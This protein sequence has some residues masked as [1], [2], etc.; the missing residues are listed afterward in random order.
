[1]GNMPSNYVRNIACKAN[2]CRYI[3]VLFQEIHSLPGHINNNIVN[4]IGKYYFKNIIMCHYLRETKKCNPPQWYEQL[5]EIQQLKIQTR[6][7]TFCAHFLS[8]SVLSCSFIFKL[9][10]LL[11]SLL[12]LFLPSFRFLGMLFQNLIYFVFFLLSAFFCLGGVAVVWAV[13][14]NTAG[15]S[16]VLKVRER[17]R[18][19]CW[20]G[21]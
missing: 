3:N 17:R 9:I 10:W 11:L 6:L 12:L 16:G 7:F 1:M 4:N 13:R 2:H 18:K 21:S 8:C 14:K 19:W 15:R 5:T 20:W